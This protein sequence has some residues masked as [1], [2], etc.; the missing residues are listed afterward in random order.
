[1]KIKISHTTSY[2]YNLTV[3]KL[4]QC[5]KLYPSICENQ[6]ILEWKI[7]SNFGKIIESHVDA[8][9]HRV[10]NIFINNLYGKLKIT[11]E[12][13]LNTKNFS[14]IVKGL[15]EKVN[16]ICFLRETNLTKPCKKI[17]KIL[18]QAGKIKDQ[19]E[20]THKLNLIV[21]NSIEYVSG[22]TT[23]STSSTE[24]LKQKKGVCQDFA[25]ILISAARLSNLPARYVNGFL[26]EQTKTGENTTHAWVEI[27]L[28]N[29]GWVAF[30]PSHKKCIDE[31]Y[32]RISVGFD[33]IDASTIKGIKTN[34]DGKEY[35]DTKVN[36]QNC[37]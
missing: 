19:I 13:I 35:L 22:S 30:D 5:L 6:E 17:K 24:A 31:N 23:T 26:L 32:V 33:F 18:E 15:N 36:I 9:G 28:K 4:I 34:Y 20:F 21:S 37:Q 14:G 27:F 12:G 25:H 10:Q 29:L 2:K 16:P 7:S 3:P 1:M 11:S 8:L